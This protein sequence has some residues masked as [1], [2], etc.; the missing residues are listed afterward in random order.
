MVG[1][2]EEVK[3]E[4]FLLN[5]IKECSKM[6]EKMEHLMKMKASYGKEVQEYLGG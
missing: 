5:L 4:H 2:V 6:C 1:R 3:F